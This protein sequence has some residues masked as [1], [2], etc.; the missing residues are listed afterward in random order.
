MLESEK[1]KEKNHPAPPLGHIRREGT[2]EAA[3]ERLDRRL[4]E[5][6]KA[7]VG[8]YCRIQMPLKLA[9]GV[10][11]TDRLGIGW[12][13]WRGGGVPRPRKETTRRNVTQGVTSPLSDASLPLPLQ[14]LQNVPRGKS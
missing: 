1:G 5:V 6:A 12:A 3:P 13:L 8:G 14:V 9:L 11:G 2:F 7:V 4:E 10:L